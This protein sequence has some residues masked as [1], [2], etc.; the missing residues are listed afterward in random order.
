MAETELK[1]PPGTA[2]EILDLTGAPPRKKA[3]TRALH[4]GRTAA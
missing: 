4:E 3:A 2:D 1:R